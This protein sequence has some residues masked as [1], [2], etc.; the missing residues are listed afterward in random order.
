M[1]TLRPI[2]TNLEPASHFAMHGLPVTATGESFWRSGSNMRQYG[3]HQ[4][5]NLQWTGSQE[6]PSRNAHVDVVVSS[7]PE[8]DDLM[9]I[10]GRRPRPYSWLRSAASRTL[11]S[12]RSLIRTHSPVRR[13]GSSIM[14][15][16]LIP[17]TDVSRVRARLRIT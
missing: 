12:P 15:A 16:T 8:V 13:P 3:L 2:D 11:S 7:P 1:P 4:C 17:A 5:P 6:L 9:S 14:P 10:V